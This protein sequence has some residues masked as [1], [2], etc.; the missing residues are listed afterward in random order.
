MLAFV[1]KSWSC[2]AQFIVQIIVQMN[3]KHLFKSGPPA[4][5]S[6]AP[7]FTPL[8]VKNVKNTPSGYFLVV[9]GPSLRT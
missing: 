9:A 1:G 5:T 4:A 3:N 7:F 6:S 8:G 2:I